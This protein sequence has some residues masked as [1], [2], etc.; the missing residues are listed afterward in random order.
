MLFCRYSLDFKNSFLY[1]GVS[2]AYFEPCLQLQ[3]PFESH[4]G[5]E[6]F[7]PQRENGLT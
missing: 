7:Q 2:I 6:L 3:K 1:F 5:F 4:I